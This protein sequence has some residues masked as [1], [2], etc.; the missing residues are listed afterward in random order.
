MRIVI[1]GSPGTGKTVISKLLAKRMKLKLVDIKKV[2]QKNKLAEGPEHEV[3]I[4][5]LSKAMEFLEEKKDFVV[6]GHLACEIGIHADFVFIL[7]T[8]PEILKQRLAKRK[9]SKE[10]LNENIM[11]EILDY[12]TQRTERVYTIAP[13]ELDTS[14]RTAEECV[15]IIMGAIKNNKK[16]LDSVDY[17]EALSRLL[18]VKYERG[19]EPD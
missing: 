18:E 5:K 6:E 14:K 2:V 4:D 12:C 10:K 16:K 1:T 9:Y 13:L 17:S 11:A 8:D 19:K 7:R 3:D 15:E